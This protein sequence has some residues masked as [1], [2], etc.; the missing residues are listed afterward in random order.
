MV[1]EV[2]SAREV[3]LDRG[4]RAI[5]LENA[6][7]VVSILPDKGADIYEF[8]HKPSGVDAMWKS[9]WGLRRPA[10]GV[11]TATSSATA[12]SETYEGGWQELFPNASS[13]CVYKGAELPF[14]GE[15]SMSGW[16][17]ELSEDGQGAE[18]RFSLRLARSPFRIT[19]IMRLDRGASSVL[20][21]QRI[22]NE[23]GQEMDYLWGHH[24]AFGAP[25]LSADC[26]VDC[27]ART[28]YG[29]ETGEPPHSP[30]AAGMRHAWPWVERDGVRTDLSL[31]PGPDQPRGLMG[32][33][34]DLEGEQSWYGI[35]NTALG[36]GFGMTWRTS[37]FPCIWYWQEMHASPDYPWYQ[38][39]YT[40]ALEPHTSHPGGGLVS[41]MARTGTHRTL[42]AGASVEVEFRAMVYDSTTG[43]AA[44]HADGTVVNR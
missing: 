41:V 42:A 35:T 22:T 24:P 11:A 4:V 21:R 5:R 38:S 26:R 3:T 28:V 39:I 12:W 30:L 19:R 8:I 40:M 10:S 23:G 33:L 27:N 43:V 16:D 14:H 20:F 17:V 1:N 7:V 25:F 32:F 13:A 31:V 15:V 36:V 29:D 34:V 37:D 9:P 6:R 44:I 18:A 2:C